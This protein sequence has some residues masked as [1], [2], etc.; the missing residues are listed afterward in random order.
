MRGY[1]DHEIAFMNRALALARR[2][3]GRVEPNPMV[4]CVLADGG[5]TIAEG[6]HRRFGGPHA[7]VVALRRAG[8]RA[9]G[10]TAYVTL[11]PCSHFGKTPPCCDALIEAGVR[12]V[13]VA[14][15]DPFPE[16]SG[17]GIRRLRKAG[18]TV[19]VGLCRAEAE[20]F[21]APYLTLLRRGRPHVILKW[22][23][24]LD[25]KI[26]TRTGDSQWIS[27]QASRRLVHRLRA[28]VDAVM[29]GINT[30][31]RDDPLLTARDVP[32]R[33]TATRVVADSRLRLPPTSRL[34]ATAAAVPLLVM[35][36]RAAASTPRA[37]RLRAAGA[38]VR[39]CRTR[40]GRLDLAHLLT[41]L[42]RLRMTNLL[43][44]GG[45]HLLADL[46][47]RNLA[48]EAYVFVAPKLIGGGD[49]VQAYPG[50]GA[51]T[52]AETPT[53]RCI[54]HRRI[55]PDLLAHIRFDPP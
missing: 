16:V 53:L 41:H 25:G 13:V 20:E 40:G 22:A 52:I 29:V 39:P 50:R 8:P 46:L 48:D 51:R 18:I 10:S 7:E 2:G 54:T 23:Q 12:R 17:R 30:V 21:N 5:R 49:A 14:M 35:T 42:G 34:V 3:Q 27:G 11:E 1:A 15:K 45:G 55:G 31:L 6:H 38:T 26:A 33:R 24:S 28:R 43:V 47:D 19:D 32:V 4:G 44:E 36:T 9:L 37:D